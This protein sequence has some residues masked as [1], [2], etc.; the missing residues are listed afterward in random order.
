M[1][2]YSKFFRLTLAAMICLFSSSVFA[3]TEI[4]VE[5]AGTL[6]TLLSTTDKELKVTGFINGTDIK[7]IRSLVTSG[8]VTSLDWTDVRI[9]SGGEAYYSGKT[10]ANDVI[11]ESMFYECSNLQQMAL[12]KTVTAIQTNAFARTGLKAIDIP[13]S[14]TQ[15]GNDAFAYCSSLETVVI[16]KKVKQ[17]NQGIF[18]S[19]NVT[20]AY[21][22]PLTP[23]GTPSYL[24]SSNPTIYVYTEVLA[25][26]KASSWK[27]YGTI[28]GGLENYY[29]MEADHST[30]LKS[31]CAECFEDAACTELKAEYQAMSDEELIA[32]VK[33]K[34]ETL[35]GQALEDEDFNAQ[36]SIFNEML[37]K[38]KNESWAAYE[39]DFR[40]HSYKPY[41]DANYWNDKMMASGGSYMGNPTGIY[42]KEDG[43]EIYVFVDEDVPSDATLYFAG[44][45]DNQLISS[46][47]MGKKLVKGLNIIEGTKNAIYYVV[48]TADTK[49]MKKTLDQWPNIKIHVEGGVV[50]GYYDIS[51]KSDAEYK[52]LLAKSTLGRFTIRGEHSLYHLKTV[53]FK[54]VFPRT[55]DKSICWF[56]SVAVWEKNLMGMTE[57][58]ALGKKAGYP[59]FLTGGEAIYPIYYNNPNFAIEGEPEDAGYANSSG[60]RTSY[61]GLDCIKNCL[62]ALNTQMDDWCAGHECGHNN[63]RAI[64]LEGC[65]EASNNVFSNLVC[66]LGGLNTSN[67]SSLSQVMEEYARCEPFFY[68]DVNSRLRFYWDLYLYY[69]LGQKNTSFYPELFKALRKDPMVLYN[70]SNNNSGGLKFVRKVCEIAQEDLTD[71]FEIWGFFEPIKSGSKIEDYGTHSIAVTK[72]NI[73][74]TKAKLAQYEKK[75]REIIFVEDRADYVLSTGFLQA[76]GKKRNGSDKVGQYGELGQFTCYLPDGCE[77]SEYVYY[78]SDSL[79]AME[80]A[81]GLGF[82]MLDAEGKLKY[83]SNAKNLCIPT[84]IDRDYT[85]YSL[86]A[87][88]SLHEVTKAGSGTVYI[89]LAAA[90]T[91][92][93]NLENDQVINLIVSGPIS[94]TDLTY[95]KQLVNK[96]NLQAIDLQQCTRYASFAASAFQNVKKLVSIKLPFVTTSIGSGAFSGSGIKF[97]EIPDKVTTIGGDAFA[98]CNSLTTVVIGKGVKTMEQ[99]IFYGSSAVKEVYMKAATPP[100]LNGVSDYLFSGKNRTIHVY[101]DAVE[102]YKAAN[103]ERF[104]TIVGDLTDEMVDGIEAVQE[105]TLPQRGSE[106]GADTFDLMGRK[107]TNLQPGSIYI[108]NGKKFMVK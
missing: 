108:R 84:S 69:H 59:W 71:F 1:K 77:P 51:R 27:S 56:D 76:A 49:S 38:L 87:D 57:E 106:E 15:L 30:I 62:N 32:N 42:A 36:Y 104:G 16:G 95:M 65:T 22:K 82:L 20:K 52:A 39:Q 70:S 103:W 6:S 13:S 19:S 88:G 48:Y 64:N 29:P 85:I 25:D 8:K 107:V 98:Y 61:N 94:A 10:T 24:F 50:N 34:V 54:T 67:G 3:V 72:T 33:Q 23:P 96:E 83:A 41:S 55:I 92:K 73:N 4:N 99:G 101:P 21:V 63:Q 89:Q 60:Y 47:T 68:R 105:E 43:D 14:V 17:L 58:V 2:N 79:Y 81:G 46:A 18:Y 97:I 102:K 37:L 40:I 12:P 91:L 11:G 28:V 5:T 75:N 86:D 44:C 93:R 53:S 26:Y 80:G 78:Q 66:Y 100:T 7:Y 31:L 35:G 45:V 90:G 9:V 74:S